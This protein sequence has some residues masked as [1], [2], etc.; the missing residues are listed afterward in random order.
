MLYIHKILDDLIRIQF[1]CEA[2]DKRHK[3][4]V[5]DIIRINIISTEQKILCYSISFN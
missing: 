5:V 1:L 4:E 3:I 2:T